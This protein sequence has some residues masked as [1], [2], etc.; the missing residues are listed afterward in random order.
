MKLQF[1]RE[2]QNKNRLNTVQKAGRVAKL[3]KKLKLPKNT[4]KKFYLKTV[5]MVNS[6]FN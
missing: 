3:Y 1:K 5:M 2:K 4:Q 6:K